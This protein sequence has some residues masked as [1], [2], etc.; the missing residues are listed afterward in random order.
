MKIEIVTFYYK[1]C[2]ECSNADYD[3]TEKN[4]GRYRCFK[5]KRVIPDI[6]KKPIPTWCPLETKEEK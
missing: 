6:Y 4:G 5:T 1:L 2:G 3:P